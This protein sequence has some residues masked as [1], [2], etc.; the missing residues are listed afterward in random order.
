MVSQGCGKVIQSGV[1]RTMH[2]L[3]GGPWRFD[4]CKKY[5][6]SKY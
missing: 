6:Y 1:L 4:F 3:V 5:Y 2:R